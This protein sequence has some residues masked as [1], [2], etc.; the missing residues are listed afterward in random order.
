M[1]FPL[2][3]MALALASLLLWPAHAK[4]EPPSF[5]RKTHFIRTEDDLRQLIVKMGDNMQEEAYIELDQ[6]LLEQGFPKSLS[7]SFYGHCSDK[8]KYYKKNKSGRIKIQIHLMDNATLL[9]AYRHPELMNRLSR[10]E[11]EA[12]NV[13]LSCTKRVIKPG[14]NRREITR[15]LHDEIVRICEYDKVKGCVNAFINHRGSCGSYAKALSLMLGMVGIPSHIISGKNQDSGSPHAWNLV[16]MGEGKWY[17]VDASKDD[18]FGGK[19]NPHKHFGVTDERM[20]KLHRW[21]HY[22]YPPTPQ[23]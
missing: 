18:R 19:K 17:H 4:L 8:F 9:A 3:Y 20:E 14:M 22:G 11:Q 15:A 23:Q 10:D 5:W 1:K 13:A 6:A 2:A 7:R 21:D 12:L 16:Q